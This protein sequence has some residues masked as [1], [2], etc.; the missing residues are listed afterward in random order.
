MKPNIREMMVRYVNEGNARFDV[1]DG[2]A[3]VVFLDENE[4]IPLEDLNYN[5]QLGFF[6]VSA[7][8]DA[9][10][11]ADSS[12]PWTLHPVVVA[13]PRNDPWRPYAILDPDGY[14]MLIG[15]KWN[16]VELHQALGVFLEKGLL[17]EPILDDDEALGW[18]WF[19]INEAIEE[20]HRYDPDEYPLGETTAQRIRMAAQRG[21]IRG[22]KQTESGRYKFSASRF[23]HWLVKNAERGSK[24]HN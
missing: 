20:A 8:P 16:V 6:R 22:W 21:A 14:G 18:R 9:E 23:R 19:T 4:F 12:N 24:P 13:D 17:S 11:E 3:G 7:F 5:R 2:R 1:Q 10:Q 15:D